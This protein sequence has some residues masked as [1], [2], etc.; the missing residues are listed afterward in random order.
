MQWVEGSWYKKVKIL[1]FVY[2][3]CES[4]YSSSNIKNTNWFG[5]FSRGGCICVLTNHKSLQ[6]RNWRMFRITCKMNS[7]SSYPWGCI[8]ANNFRSEIC[9]EEIYPSELFLEGHRRE[10]L[11]LRIVTWNY[12]YYYNL[13]KKRYY[14]KSG[15]PVSSS[16]KSTT[17]SL[18]LSLC[19]DRY[20]VLWAAKL[21]ERI[22]AKRFL[23]Q[24]ARITWKMLDPT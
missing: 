4:F 9:K 23:L 19:L 17:L 16:S 18:S 15:V 13:M 10:E 1:C 24:R 11:L 12:R 3:K 5:P 20:Y 6:I 7:Q 21:D 22:D 2:R 8:T 14:A